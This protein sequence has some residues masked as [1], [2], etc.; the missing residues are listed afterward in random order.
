MVDDGRVFIG[1]RPKYPG[2]KT[3][4]PKLGELKWHREHEREH[5]LYILSLRCE[6]VMIELAGVEWSYGSRDGGWRIAVIGNTVPLK[7]GWCSV[8]K[9][10][11]TTAAE[12]MG[13]A[14]HLLC[15]ILRRLLEM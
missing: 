2:R 15:K 14:Q 7:D 1:P 4:M 12:A 6:D 8:N 9:K 3:E 5:Y 13:N 11:Y 10:L